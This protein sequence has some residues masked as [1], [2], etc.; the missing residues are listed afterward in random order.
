MPHVLYTEDALK[1]LEAIGHVAAGRVTAKITAYAAAPLAFANLVKK[2]QGA[3]IL[4]LRV[5]DYRVLFTEDG[6]I[7]RVLR[8]GHRREVYR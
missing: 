2:L 4:R 8:V 3:D 6:T 5:G 1:D 7:L